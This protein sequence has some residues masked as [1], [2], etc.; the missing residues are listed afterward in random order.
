[1]DAVTAAPRTYMKLS[2][3]VLFLVLCVSAHADLLRVVN[4]RSVA[5]VG[6]IGGPDVGFVVQARSQLEFEVESG[7][8]ASFLEYNDDAGSYADL[9]EAPS[10]GDVRLLVVT[11]WGTSDVEML[12]QAEPRSLVLAVSWLVLVAGFFM[13]YAFLSPLDA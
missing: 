2:L 11:L 8:F 13:G 5:V 1:M 7:G 3:A 12:R 6:L 4:Q 9:P 10:D